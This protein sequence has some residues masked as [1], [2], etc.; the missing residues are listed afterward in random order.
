MNHGRQ[1]E[2]EGIKVVSPLGHHGGLGGRLE[3][4]EVGRRETKEKVCD[5]EQGEE[6]TERKKEARVS[7]GDVNNVW[8]RQ[9]RQG[10][11][12][13]EDVSHRLTLTADRA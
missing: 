6:Y 8:K 5:K 2:P 10:D 4:R 1:R 9:K 11:A 12:E 13:D 7:R 3:K